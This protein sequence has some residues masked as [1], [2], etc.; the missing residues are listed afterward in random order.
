MTPALSN[1]YFYL[2]QSHLP[3]QAGA[4]FRSDYLPTTPVLLM[5]LSSIS[6]MVVRHLEQAL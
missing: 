2:L 4:G 3:R 1:C 6:S 5:S